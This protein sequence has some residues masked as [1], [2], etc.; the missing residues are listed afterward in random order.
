MTTHRA[1]EG[2]PFAIFA[3]IG[4]IIIGHSLTQDSP[5]TFSRTLP[6]LLM[7]ILGELVREWTVGRLSPTADEHTMRWIRALVADRPI[8]TANPGRA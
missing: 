1:Y 3:G 8:E 2:E 4:L 5:A 6:F 7:L